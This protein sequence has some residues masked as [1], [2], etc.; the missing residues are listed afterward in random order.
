MRSDRKII[1]YKGQ[2]YTN[3]DLINSLLRLGICCGDTICMHTELF[4]FG[5]PLLPKKEFL[6]S[7]L[8]CFYEVI[9]QEG[10]LIMPTF[11][12]S[13]CKNEIYNKNESKTKMGA[14]NEFFRRQK[15]VKR[16]DD[17]IFSFALKGKKEKLFLKETTSCFGKNCVYDIL[18][19]EKGKYIVFGGVGHTLTHFAEEK[20]GITYR[21]HKN[22]SGI[23]IDEFGIRKETSI[24]YYVRKLEEK[25]IPNLTKIIKT[26]SLIKSHKD[27][28]YAGDFIHIYDA[29]EY[30]EAIINVIKKDKMALVQ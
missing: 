22:F 26:V 17:P 19:K 10:T 29:N 4:K 28:K 20:N 30:V 7:I 14:L 24:D 27:I 13:Y 21:Y 2:E 16:T 1:E 3:T 6:D 25:S 11:T 18:L 9:G 8:E 5:N 12:Y 15:G 23:L